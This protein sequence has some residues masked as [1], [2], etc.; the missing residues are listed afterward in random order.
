MTNQAT[1]KQTRQPQT[2]VAR[3]EALT[4]RPRRP[5]PLHLGAAAISVVSFA[6]LLVWMAG[7]HAKVSPV[8]AILDTTACV[9]AAMEF[10]TRS[11]WRWD[12][13]GYLLTHIFDFI[14]IVPALLLVHADVL[15][16]HWWAWVILAARS[17]RVADRLLGDGFVELSVARV[18]ERFEEAVTD[19]VLLRLLRGVER[20]LEGGRLGQGSRRGAHDAPRE[21]AL[22]CASRSSA[23]RQGYLGAVTGVGA[24][25]AGG[26]GTYVRCH[27]RGDE[28]PRSRP[29]DARYVGGSAHR[30]PRGD[31]KTGESARRAQSGGKRRSGALRRPEQWARSWHESMMDLYG[32]TVTWS[33]GA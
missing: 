25:G 16:A 1:P 18:I 22:S 6:T 19:R 4:Q 12:R 21:H 9:L 11:G 24:T 17:T 32:A 13:R 33:G 3:L 31:L 23:L 27:R 8:W 2:A 5:A 15:Y 30:S 10:A 29:R 20:G 28:Q 14:A 7:N 26:R